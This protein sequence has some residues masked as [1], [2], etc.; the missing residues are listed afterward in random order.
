MMLPLGGCSSIGAG[1]LDRD[2]TDY[3]NAFA[4]SQK[5]QTLLN[6]VRLRYGDVPVLLSL[7]QIVSGYNLE[8]ELGVSADLVL[9]PNPQQTLGPNSRFVYRDR[10]TITYSPVAGAD[11]ADS[12]LVPIQPEN[13]FSLVE[14]GLELELIL[15]LTISAINGVVNRTGAQAA[16]EG[17]ARF[18]ELVDHLRVLQRAGALGFRSESSEGGSRRFLYLDQAPLGP[19]DVPRL[20]AVRAL[21]GVPEALEEFEIIYGRFPPEPST[22][23]VLTRS[24]LQILLAMSQFVAVPEQAIED[25]EVR[26]SPDIRPAAELLRVRSG[27]LPPVRSF[28]TVEYDASYFWIAGDDF[29][30]K[31]IFSFMQILLGLAERTTDKAMPILTIPTS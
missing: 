21:L 14:S 3:A 12:L 4:Q 9:S 1:V 27:P 13:I 23:A 28:V 17:K 29:T 15:P 22:L 5:Q 2:R 20:D 8:G 25:G 6:L 18:R 31:R 7:S 24:G 11:L 19:Q 30:S 16:A 10:P 26:P